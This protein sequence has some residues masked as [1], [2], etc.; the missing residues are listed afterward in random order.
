M[1]YPDAPQGRHEEVIR[2]EQAPYDGVDRLRLVIEAY[3]LVPQQEGGGT[4]AGMHQGG[5]EHAGAG[6]GTRPLGV[7]R[8]DELAHDGHQREL[9]GGAGHQHQVGHVVGDAVGRHGVRAQRHD[10]GLRQQAAALEDDALDGDRDADEQDLADDGKVELPDA[11]REDVH[12][13]VAVVH[14]QQAVDGAGGPG[15][16]QRQAGAVHPEA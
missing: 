7:V 10:E 5:D 3:V 8:A 15:H 11:Q 16:H 2:Q 6:G 4:G 13:F 1:V 12:M 14:Q 9:E